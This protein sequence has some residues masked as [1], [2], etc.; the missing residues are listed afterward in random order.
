MTRSSDGANLPRNSLSVLRRLRVLEI[1]LSIARQPGL[2]IG[3]SMRSATV[4]HVDDDVN[5]A[6]FLKDAFER[7]G[8]EINVEFRSALD[9]ARA[10]DYMIGTPPYNDRSCHPIPDL[11]VLDLNMPL[12]DGFQFLE[13]LRK[14]N[15]F[16]TVPVYILSSSDDPCDMTRACDLGASG[17]LVKQVDCR[18]TAGFL[19]T[20]LE[21]LL[22]TEAA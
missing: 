11:I 9:G 13:C 16:R 2:H 8:S 1:L 7:I 3:N 22:G 14:Q 10:L 15:R 18:E 6:F 12:V 20:A 21:N 17:Y 5:D 4:L 19:N